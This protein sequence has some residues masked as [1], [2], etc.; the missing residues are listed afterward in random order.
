MVEIAYLNSVSFIKKVTFAQRV[1]G[2]H[3]VDVMRQDVEIQSTRTLKVIDF[4]FYKT[5]G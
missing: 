5:L 2:A 1:E 3:R 4:G